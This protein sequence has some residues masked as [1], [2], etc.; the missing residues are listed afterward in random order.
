MGSVTSALTRTRNALI[1]V[2]TEPQEEAERSQ[3]APESDNGRKKTA[4]SSHRSRQSRKQSLSEVLDAQDNGERVQT[5]KGVQTQSDW[6]PEGEFER[7][8]PLI[9]STALRFE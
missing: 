5:S 4:R 1:K 7:F 3:S 6:F 2:G 8:L 9:P